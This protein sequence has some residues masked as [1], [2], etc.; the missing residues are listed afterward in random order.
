MATLTVCSLHMVTAAHAHNGAVAVAFP[1]AGIVIDGDL[2]DWPGSVPSYA[3]SRTEY[4]V[5]PTGPGDLSAHV[6]FAFDK[7]RSSLLVAFDVRDD[8]PMVNTRA[9]RG[10]DS[11]D[12]IEIY[13][14]MQHGQS[15]KVRQFT[16]RGEGNA[17]QRIVDPDPDPD[18]EV[19]VAWRREGTRQQYEWRIDLD[20]DLMSQMSSGRTMSIDVVVCDYDPDGSFSWVAWGRRTEKV[21]SANRRGDVVLVADADDLGRVKGKALWDE[22]G[23]GISGAAIKI[24]A[25]NDSALWVGLASKFGGAFDVDLPVGPYVATVEVGPRPWIEIPIDV[26]AETVRNIE[27][28]VPSP[29][30]TA[31]PLGEGNSPC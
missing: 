7:Q 6:R 10:W 18:A 5:A 29:E 2:R 25:V 21:G 1:V 3:V 26:E 23:S 13:L 12:G 8:H 19:A 14:D 28:R 31:R 30:G 4:G 20:P 9:D 11:E 17:Q 22:L 24:Q 15:S 16:L 27:F